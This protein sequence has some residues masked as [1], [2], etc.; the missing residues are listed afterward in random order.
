MKIIIYSNDI[1]SFFCK[2][3]DFPYT[4]NICQAKV[5]ESVKAAKEWAESKS[6]ENIT[7]LEI[8]S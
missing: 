2:L 4:P 3:E 8:K 6:F 5:F 1:K 7:F